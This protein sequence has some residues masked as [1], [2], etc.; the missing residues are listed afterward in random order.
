MANKSGKGSGFEREI[1]KRLSLWWTEGDRDDV[2]WRTQNSGGRATIRRKQGKG[3]AGQHS[4]LTYTDPIAKPLFDIVLIECKRGYKRWS[5][6]DM[7]DKGKKAARQTFEEWAVKADVDRGAAGSTWAW[8]IARRDARQT[9]IAVPLDFMQRGAHWFGKYPRPCLRVF[10]NY[11][12]NGT[13]DWYVLPLE[14][15]LSW[16]SPKALLQMAKGA[17]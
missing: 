17:K 12:V 15:F 16:C 9:I 13:G 10:C 11:G 1:A 14:L 4:D 8:I 2:M 3:L 6:L 5:L 7:V